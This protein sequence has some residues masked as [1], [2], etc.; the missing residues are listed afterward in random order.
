[1]CKLGASVSTLD[2]EFYVF[3]RNPDGISSDPTVYLTMLEIDL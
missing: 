1:M 2:V 3:L